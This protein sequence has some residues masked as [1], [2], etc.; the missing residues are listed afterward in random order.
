MIGIKA[1]T[2][3]SPHELDRNI[4]GELQWSDKAM[5]S[6]ALLDIINKMVMDD[7][8]ERY[9]SASAVLNEI[10]KL[11]YLPNINSAPEYY[12]YLDDSDIET[13]SWEEGS[14]ETTI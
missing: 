12:A 2:G 7:V 11:I 13:K 6:H 8:K 5:V 1:F 4:H 10:N 3:V 9:Q 14:S